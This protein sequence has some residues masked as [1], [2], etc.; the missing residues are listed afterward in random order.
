[1]PDKIPSIIF[2]RQLLMFVAIQVLEKLSHVA[3][4]SMQKE[5]VDI[6]LFIRL[7]SF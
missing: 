3:A 4:I 2:C 1:M 5:A 7:L 6:N